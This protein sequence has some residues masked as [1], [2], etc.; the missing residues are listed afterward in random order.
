MAQYLADG[1]DVVVY[2]QDVCREAPP[3]AI[4]VVGTDFWIDCCNTREE[5][6]T[7]AGSLGLKVGR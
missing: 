7:L 3:F 2:P 5:A 6:V 1:A 4:G